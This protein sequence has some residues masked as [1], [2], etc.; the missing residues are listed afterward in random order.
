MISVRSDRC[1]YFTH[2]SSFHKSP[3]RTRK[4]TMYCVQFQLEQRVIKFSI[5]AVTDEFEASSENCI[6]YILFATKECFSLIKRSIES[7]FYRSIPCLF[8]TRIWTSSARGSINFMCLC[9]NS[10]HHLILILW[11]YK[12]FLFYLCW[13]RDACVCLP[14]LHLF[15][16]KFIIFSGRKSP[17]KWYFH[18][19]G[20]SLWTPPSLGRP[21]A[22]CTTPYQL[23]AMPELTQMIMP[24]FA[25]LLFNERKRENGVPVVRSLECHDKK[26]ICIGEDE[27]LLSP[28]RISPTQKP[29]ILQSKI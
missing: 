9:N 15:L 29:N 3:D 19:L 6:L 28:V 7:P 21:G 1:F 25:R 14:K 27:F 23:H 10:C 26:K 2:A 4:R 24:R 17:K 22:H 13:L 8:D 12:I 11:I 20:H 5:A 18:S 16:G